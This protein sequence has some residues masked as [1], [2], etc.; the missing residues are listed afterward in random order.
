MTSAILCGYCILA[1]TLIVEVVIA[2]S[3]MVI[4]LRK[5]GYLITKKGFENSNFVEMLVDEEST[6]EKYKC[7][8]FKKIMMEE[9]SW[10][11]ETEKVQKRR[12]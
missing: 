6:R 5:F 1:A 3:A 10:K 9:I 2:A 7:E 12:G 11:K 4:L 8:G